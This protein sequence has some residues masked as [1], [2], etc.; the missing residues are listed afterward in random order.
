MSGI[1]SDGLPKNHRLRHLLMNGSF[2]VE[3]L[4]EARH[5]TVELLNLFIK[6]IHS[7]SLAKYFA[8]LKT[9]MLALNQIPSHSHQ[10]F[11]LLNPFAS[12]GLI[13]SM[14]VFQNTAL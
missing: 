13:P 14:A 1:D 9:S 10:S 2:I 6:N 5:S 12:N 8:S 4:T 3:S 11:M 7:V